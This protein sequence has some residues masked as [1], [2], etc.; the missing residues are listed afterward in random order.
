MHPAPERLLDKKGNIHGIPRH[1]QDYI[2]ADHPTH[3]RYLW[4]NPEEREITIPLEGTK[5]PSGDQNGLRIFHEIE[6]GVWNEVTL[7]PKG[8]SD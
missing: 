8:V 5:R 2:D 7:P 4:G 6:P 1:K 3:E